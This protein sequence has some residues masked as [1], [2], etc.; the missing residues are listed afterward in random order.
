MSQGQSNRPA[1]RLVPMGTYSDDALVTLAKA[2]S[3]VGS[4]NHK[5]HPGDY[6]FIPPVSPRA[7]KS[8]CDD[9]RPLLKAEAAKLFRQGVLAEMISPFA[10]GSNPKYVWAVDAKGEVYEAKAKPGVSR[11]Q[12]KTWLIQSKKSGAWARIAEA[13][14]PSAQS[15][16]LRRRSLTSG[17]L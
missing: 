16:S 10:P 1:R 15:T 11:G 6:G 17:R 13:T 3:Y 2:I 7:S 9:L 14:S 4:A 5:L 12:G 8:V